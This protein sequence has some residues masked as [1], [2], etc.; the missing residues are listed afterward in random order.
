[1]M[2]K[3]D[4]YAVAAAILV[5]VGIVGVVARKSGKGEGATNVDTS[6][7]NASSM[8]ELQ[9]PPPTSHNHTYELLGLHSTEVEEGFD[10]FS[11]TTTTKVHIRE[12]GRVFFELQ[13]SA[14]QQGRDPVEPPT[15][16]HLVFVYR[17]GFDFMRFESPPTANLLLDGQRLSLG[18][19][20][21]RDDGDQY[22][23]T[24]I[25][26][27]D[28]LRIVGASEVEGRFD[29][30]AK[31][32]GGMSRKPFQVDAEELNVLRDFASRLAPRN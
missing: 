2:K 14:E 11:G 5:G 17:P 12:F 32:E 6:N 10:E 18:T 13:V 3:S 16:V 21:L 8:A 9:F 4:M 15:T 25:G 29:D 24:T 30:K 31:E 20:A 1:M 23:S 26:I 7:G 22:M 28:F 27:R 19:L